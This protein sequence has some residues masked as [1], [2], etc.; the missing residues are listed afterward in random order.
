MQKETRMLIISFIFAFA[1]EITIPKTSVTRVEVKL[2]LFFG[3]LE[4]F[5]DR[6]LSPLVELTMSV[7]SSSQ[8]FLQ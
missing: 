4:L 5:C 1:N 6:K 7:S 3:N 2:K 8:T